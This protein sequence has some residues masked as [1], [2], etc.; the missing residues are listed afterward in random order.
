[1][2]IHVKPSMTQWWHLPSLV[3]LKEEW[4][5]GREREV[6]QDGLIECKWREIDR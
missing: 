3:I 2:C 5:T 6:F 4:E 1:M